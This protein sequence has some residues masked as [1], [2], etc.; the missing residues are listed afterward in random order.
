MW[1]QVSRK[2]AAD[3]RG[4]SATVQAVA[5]LS[6]D[7]REDMFAL[8]DTYYTETARDLFLSDLSDKDSAILLYDSVG[9]LRGFTTLKILE[10]EHLGLTQRAIFSGDT[11]IHHDYWGE[12]SLPFT[13]IRLAGQIKASAPR[14]PLYWLLIVK[15]HRTYR[16]LQAFSRDY[17]PH[18]QRPTPAHTQSLMHA[19]GTLCFDEH[20][21]AR[22][23]II[24]FPSSRGQL[25]EAW[26]NVGA[27]DL[28]RPE[29]RYFL[30]R[31]PGYAHGEELLCLTQLS[32][33]NLR[34]LARR[35]FTQDM[36]E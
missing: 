2:P 19:L 8:Y 20:Y 33:D 9:A 31:N 17:F 13:W 12:Q 22:R 27:K 36:H 1:S 24:K 15:G 29:V 25:R 26:A 30:Q 6:S 3:W 4:L 11:L 14:I 18:Y 28:R 21:D 34:P 16:Y 7:T 10:F 35:L 32:S 23:G 5:T